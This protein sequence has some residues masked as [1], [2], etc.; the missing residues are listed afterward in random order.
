LP[1]PTYKKVARF[2]L[3]L[4]FG[5]SMIITSCI[6]E[7]ESPKIEV[8][9]NS[10]LMKVKEWFEENKTKLR[11][12]ERGS[13][14]R[15]DAQELILPFFEKEPDWD[16]FHH[17]YFAD[18]RE[19]FEVSLDN[20]T[21]YFPKSML[22]SFPNQ[23]PKEIAV[24]NIMF[25]KHPTENRFDP[26]IAR[27]FPSDE[28]SINRQKN[29]SYNSLDELW[30]G[31]IDIFTYDE[32]H[33][34]GFTYED[35]QLKS[36]NIYGENANANNRM[37]GDCTT[38]IR[39]V[40]WVTNDPGS[41][42]E[43]SAGYGTTYHSAL[44]SETFCTGSGS[45]TPSGGVVD[46]NGT[47]YYSYGG[48]DSGISCTGSCEY[49]V[50]VVS[51]PESIILNLLTN[52]CASKIFKDIMK[53]SILKSSIGNLNQTNDIIQLLQNADDFDFIVTNRDFGAD[54][55]NAQTSPS[56]IYN[57]TTGKLEITI[58]F[59][60][61]YLQNATQLSIARSFIHEAIHAYLLYAGYNSIEDEE[62]LVGLRNLANGD[63]NDFHHSF[64]P[65]Y[66]ESIGYS[67]AEW[68]R[69]YGNS[70][71]NN[72]IYF[73][74]IAWGGLTH[75]QSGNN[76]PTWSTPFDI[77]FPDSTTK[78]NIFN[79]IVNESKGNYDAEGKPC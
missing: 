38:T 64:M 48:I 17:Y 49:I 25:I 33:F 36:T 73:D 46:V 59:N 5:F 58:E 37:Q 79:K 27:Y 13:N 10:Q 72:R 55:A 11:L 70:I 76:P 14:F 45:Y 16:K 57:S 4:I 40:T 68:N 61:R 2:G 9:E 1:P 3:A 51:R 62:L 47:P 52:P 28:Y 26:L 60:D 6:Q 53:S 8:K 34:I 75:Q 71:I 15:T 63:L 43:D 56:I 21:K 24:Q 65:K 18:G 31:S 22:D 39:E 42:E 7:P 12:P 78:T 67:L 50:P 44:V 20:A 69:R 35:G 30:S 23:D 74:Q 66:I 41:A 54:K 19:V 77:R 29:I 32:H